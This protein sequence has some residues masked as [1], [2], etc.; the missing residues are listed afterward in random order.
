MKKTDSIYL[1]DNVS[2][3]RSHPIV[4]ISGPC[5]IES[6][7]HCLFMASSIKEICEQLSIP[8][9]FKASFDKANRT[10]LSNYRGFHIDKAVDIFKKVKEETGVPILT[11]FHES[12]QAEILSECVDILQ[13]PAFLCRQTDMIVAASKTNR[14]VNI[15]KG[16]FVSGYDTGR[17]VDKATQSGNSNILLTERGNTFGYGDYIVDYRNLVVMREYAPVIFDAT[18]CIQKGCS[19]G[20]SGSY[21][22]FIE[23]LARAAIAV[24]VDGLF[25]ETHDR[26]EDALSDGTSSIE[27]S[28]LKNLLSRL[29]LNQ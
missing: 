8:Y 24:G 15:K 27:L 7:D 3:G 1:N 16:Q 14:I 11:D 10:R 12:W 19:G 17:M 18:H 5:V 26:P 6:L 13:V 21:R 25:M 20:S 9:V 22:H 29:Q 2:F 28:K 4:L 23:P